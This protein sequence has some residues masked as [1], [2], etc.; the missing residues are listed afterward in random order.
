MFEDFKDRVREHCQNEQKLLSAS[1]S[2]QVLEK[3]KKEGIDPD[4]FTLRQLWPEVPTPQIYHNFKDKA[5][6]NWF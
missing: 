3:L 5:K 6:A 2:P 1:L 4:N